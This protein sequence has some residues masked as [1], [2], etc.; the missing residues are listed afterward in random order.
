MVLIFQYFHG[1]NN[2]LIVW[3]L[4]CNCRLQD[5][6]DAQH[7]HK[8]NVKIWKHT[9]QNWTQK[10]HLR[11][12]GNIKSAGNYNGTGDQH[13]CPSLVVLDMPNCFKI[14]K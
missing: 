10:K 6:Q 3:H 13:I 4:L 7:R 12:G 1:G 11:W 5:L 8:L 2:S 14:G 9:Q